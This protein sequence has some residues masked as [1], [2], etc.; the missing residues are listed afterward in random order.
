[1]K[2]CVQYWLAVGGA[3]AAVAPPAA[4]Q[5]ITAGSVQG[6]VIGDAGQSIPEAI[7]T[8]RDITTGLERWAE[9]APDGQFAFGLL[10]PGMYELKAEQLGYRPT[11]VRDVRVSLG[12]KVILTVVILPTTPPVA[13]IDSVDLGGTPVSR[14]GA[15]FGFPYTL[16]ERMPLGGRDL[17]AFS[18]LH[19]RGDDGLAVDGLPERFTDLSVDG[20]THGVARHVVLPTSPVDAVGLPLLGYQNAGILHSPGDLEWGDFTGSLLGGF[21][22]RGTKDF[23]VRLF[24]DFSGTP[25]AGSD[26]FAPNDVSHSSWRGGLVLGGPIVRDTARFA[27]GGEA[28]RL[29]VPRAQPWVP[30]VWDSAMVAIAVDTHGVDLSRYTAPRVAERELLSAFGRFDWDF[31]Q[32]HRASVSASFATVKDSEAE[33]GPGGVITIGGDVESTDIIGTGSVLSRFS[34]VTGNELR[35][36]F[37]TSRRTYLGNDLPATRVGGQFVAFG[38]DRAQPGSFK[39]TGV[40]VSNAFQLKLGGVQLKLGAFAGFTSHEQTHAYGDAGAYWFSDPDALASGRGAFVG[41]ITGVPTTSFSSTRL[42]GLLQNTWTVFR[43]LDLLI[44]L[45]WDGEWLPRKK[46]T[47][48]QRWLELTGLRN[49]SIRSFVSK[50]SPR[51][52]F[53]WRLGARSEWIVQAVAAQ[54]R[55]GL[56]PGVMGEAIREFGNSTVS[57]GIGNVG[58]LGVP[59]P[60]VEETGARMT[61]IGTDYREPGTSALGF[62]IARRLGQ[63]GLLE[64]STHYR[65]TDRLRRRHDLNRLPAPAEFDQNG[66]PVY[67]TLVKEGSLVAPQPGSNRRFD[68][69]DLVSALDPD[70]FSNYWGISARLEQPVGRFLRILASYTYS[71]TT[72]N[73]LSGRYEGPDAQLTPFPDSL[74]TGDWAEGT[75]DF[76]VP[77]RAALGIEVRPLGRDGLTVAALYRF[78]SG[79]PYTTGFPR[80]VDANGDGSDSNDPAFVDAAIDGVTALASEYPCL[81]LGRFSERNA[82][83][84][85]G[86]S[87]LNL[88]VGLGPI[89]LAGYPLELWVEMLNLTDAELVVRDHALYVVDPNAPLARDAGTVTVP[90]RV[91][92]NFGEPVAYRGSGRSLR[93]GLRVNY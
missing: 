52:S 15:M 73:W 29:Q 78:S 8:L 13:D 83:R 43:G 60:A 82:C 42:G 51:F 85:P 47:L 88:R 45:R 10:Y 7:V 37:E 70:G 4:A 80:G 46:F 67:G 62:G 24:A 50:W 65:H 86:L 64:I 12:E 53:R 92:E 30:T 17:S 76:D 68:E 5:S 33:V 54:Y 49:D 21:A 93:F 91:N 3:L 14:P 40:T 59:G 77:H 22:R 38:T 44:G 6:A 20:V 27:I 66:R 90:L 18:A 9:S 84:D 25:G 63:G 16:A 87:T 23:G 55:G 1:M 79:L 26:Y 69:F 35:I 36:G 34:P 39:R 41:S 81:Q 72:D 56:D 2:G 31:S 57:R 19:T 11:M 61:I 74:D 75:S 48:N 58:W 71:R 89:I 28:Q 32:N